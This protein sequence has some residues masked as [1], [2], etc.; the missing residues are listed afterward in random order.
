MKIWNLVR[1]R[2]SGILFALEKAEFGLYTKKRILVRTRKSIWF[3]NK[4]AEFG[5]Y[6]K[7]RN[8]VRTRKNG[9]WF[10]YE[11][12][13]F[14]SYTKKRNL[15]EIKIVLALKQLSPHVGRKAK[16]F[17]RFRSEISAE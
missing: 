8:L 14:D 5:L 9:I 4:K 17:H 7:K 16:L 1:T 3:I 13:D 12:A 15:Y 11:K 2:K 10:I 6:M